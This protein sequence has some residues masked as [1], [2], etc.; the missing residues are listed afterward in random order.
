MIA[1]VAL[2]LLLASSLAALSACTAERYWA[3]RGWFADPDGVRV[4]A[5]VR[6]E[7]GDV[8]LPLTFA[9]AHLTTLRFVRSV[10]ASVTGDQILVRAEVSLPGPRWKPW[11]GASV[12]LGDVPPGPYEVRYLQ[13]DGSSLPLASVEIPR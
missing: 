13:A 1:R 11:D 2:L 9:P 3:Q 8:A 7:S 10:E 12:P 4:G 5:P 6:L